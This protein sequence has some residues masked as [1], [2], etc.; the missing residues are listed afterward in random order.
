VTGQNGGAG[1]GRNDGAAG[2]RNDGGGTGGAPPV[3]DAERDRLAGDHDAWMRWGP[4]LAERAWGT[5]RED[6]SPDGTAWDYLPHDQARSRAYRW[7][8]DGMAGVCDDQQR[9][10]LALAVWNGHDPIL[11]ERMFGLTGPQGRH[12]EDVKEYWW[13]A[14]A[15][16]SHAWLRWQYAYPL[17]GYPYDG[18]LAGNA[19]R[20]R[21]QPEYELIDTGVFD[22]EPGGTDGSARWADITVEYAKA[23]PDDIVMRIQVENMSAQPATVHVLPTLWLRNTWSWGPDGHRGEIRVEDG[24]LLAQHPTLGTML[25][26][27]STASDGTAPVPLFC[28]NETNVARLFGATPST[29][30]PKDGINDHVTRGAATV[31]P[32]LVGTKAAL[33]YRLQL[34]GRGRTEI[35]LRLASAP[36]G[37]VGVPAPSTGTEALDVLAARRAEADTFHA[38]LLPAAATPAERA[39]HRQAVAGMIWGKCW[40]F[41]DVDVWLDGDPYQPKPP[42]SRRTGRNSGWRHV[43]NWDVL[44]M[45]DPW[46]YPWYAAWDLAFHTVALAHVDARFAKDQ[47]LLLLREWYMHPNG[48]LPAY[49]WAFGDVNPPVHAWAAL[50][51]FEIDGSTDFD[52]LERVLHKLLLNFT[53]WV[54]R[55][56]AEGNNIFE[57]GFL[58]MDNIG[59]IDRSNQVPAGFVLEQSDGT[60]WMAVYCLDL[61]QICLKLAA[62]HD[63]VYNDLAVK[64]L[65]HFAL[66]AGT[67]RDSALWNDE[68]GFYYDVLTCNGKVTPLRVQSMVGLIPLFAARV[69]SDEALEKAPHIGEH[70]AW[71]LAN[72]PEFAA[73]I[74]GDDQARDPAGRGGAHLLSIVGL[75]KL[76]RVLARVLD[77]QQFL[78]PTGVRSVS[79]VHADHPFVLD[80]GQGWSA[81]VDYEPGESTSGLFGG[82]SNWRGPVWFPV[83]HLLVAALRR[84][85]DW[86]GDGFTVE[87]P[88]GSGR[89]VTLAEVADELTGRLVSTF[90]PGEDGVRPFAR[91]AWARMPAAWRDRLQFNEYFHGET[92][93]GLGASHQTGWTGLV[94]DLLATLTA[95]RG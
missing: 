76:A 17:D 56:D 15:V 14:D 46:E 28:E 11:K 47:L 39:V 53:W 35:V 27:E 40:Y 5:V 94:I 7:N 30:Y 1:A 31:N 85:G 13:Y 79:R 67:M 91:P 43:N 51:V 83:N 22:P 61:F 93:A 77:E 33:W 41:Y 71:F 62:G 4:Y 3:A 66:V 25:L 48:Q 72:K 6:Y 34:A 82:N 23:G 74:T 81:S 87:L 55:K 42:A 45:P 44:S 2:G 18:L 73:V 90:L 29:P 60:S 54:N 86:T 70:L 21:D 24:I 16:P 65:E 69:A 12:G 68:D 26:A 37:G 63:V 38:G 75:D 89:R 20:T 58:G 19:A 64:F 80:L 57:G 32:A 36:N 49:E 52:F 95:R 84:Y 78:A 59:P 8:E 50:R 10:C 9:L 92:G 88:T